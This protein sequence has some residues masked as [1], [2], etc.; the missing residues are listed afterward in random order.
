MKC[1]SSHKE[2]RKVTEKPTKGTSR[3]IESKKIKIDCQKIIN[4]D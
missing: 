2:G 3:K 4:G 1:L